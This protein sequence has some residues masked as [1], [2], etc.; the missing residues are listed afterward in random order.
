L[1]EW[2]QQGGAQDDSAAV[3][4][5]DAL[6]RLE[7]KVAEN[8]EDARRRVDAGDPLGAVGPCREAIRLGA[9]TEAVP[10]LREA[11]RQ[12]RQMVGAK[13]WPSWRVIA[14]AA[15]GGL[16]L[17][18][19]VIAGA[20]AL[21]PSDGVA[22][23]KEQIRRTEQRD[24]ER[25][26]MMFLLAHRERSESPAVAEDLLAAEAERLV[27]AEQQKLAQLRRESLAKGGRPRDADAA[28]ESALRQLREV[29]ATGGDSATMGPRLQ[30]ALAQIDR[31]VRMYRASAGISA[32]EAV[33]GV[34]SLL[35]KD[36][37]FGGGGGAR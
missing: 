4:A 11:R 20:L 19:L 30:Q 22:Q 36:P 13:R 35:A 5:A 8:L 12:A 29:I 23:L 7:R 9:E 34:E 1:A 26:A 37:L 2:N 16:A 21:R 17:L 27:Q 14:V 3:R 18:L 33:R 28:A 24:G 15:G 10:L 6:S 31:A 32:T 25:T